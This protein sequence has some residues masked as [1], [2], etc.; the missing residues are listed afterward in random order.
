MVNVADKPITVRRAT[1]LRPAMQA[2]TAEAIRANQIPRRCVPS[3]PP[4]GHGTNEPTVD[5]LCHSLNLDGVEVDFQWLD[6]QTRILVRT[7]C[8]PNRVEIR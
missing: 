2:A 1:I 5:P 6:D 3:R 7:G 8:C 4:G